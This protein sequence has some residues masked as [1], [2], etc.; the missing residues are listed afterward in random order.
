MG[1]VYYRSK[2]GLNRFLEEHGGTG[3]PGAAVTGIEMLAQFDL[4]LMVKA[5]VQWGLFGGAITALGTKE[6]HRRYLPGA[7]DLSLLGCFA[8]TETGHGSDVQNLETTATFDP[9]AEEFVINSPTPSSRKDYIGNAGR[10][11][12]MA[13]VFAQ[14]V[15]R[16][17][18][19]GVHCFLVPI[20]DEHGEMM[21][22]LQESVS[23]IRLV[24]SYGAERRRLR[25]YKMRA[26]QFRGGFHD[27][28]IRKGGLQIFPRLVAASHPDA[29]REDRLASSGIDAPAA[30]P[31]GSLVCPVP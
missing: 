11:A 7:M 22:I 30:I 16:G 17:E 1:T 26:R 2:K 31:S 20:R 13:A 24:K 21:S 14:L 3:D 25:V 10:H 29:D 19:Y 5:G 12:T 27:F 18:T 6:H 23:G 15:T 9:A 28:V 4:S 8:M